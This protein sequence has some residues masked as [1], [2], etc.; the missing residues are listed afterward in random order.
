[1]DSSRAIALSPSSFLSL[2]S[3]RTTFDI[4]P[5]DNVTT[6]SP[7][8]S[9]DEWPDIPSSFLYSL[10][11]ICKRPTQCFNVLTRKMNPASLIQKKETLTGL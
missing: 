7:Y 10:T 3:P 8:A 11:P 9:Q 2:L 6:L 4:S 1:M 5:Q